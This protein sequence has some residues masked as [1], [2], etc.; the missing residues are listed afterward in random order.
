MRLRLRFLIYFLLAAF[1]PFTALGFVVQNTLIRQLEED[2]RRQLETRVASAE[3]RTDEMLAAD[4]RAVEALCAH[5]LVV[6]R[7]LLDL[8]TDRFGPQQEASMV[9]LL[10]PMMRG[11]RFDVL[12]LLDARSGERRGRILGAGHYAERVGG[13]EPALVDAIA[14]AGD[15]P[16]VTQVRVREGTESASDVDVLVSGC[17][18]ARDGA[19]VAVLAGRTL[20]DRFSAGIL[21]DV[22]PVHFAL[23][24]PGAEVELPGS[25]EP[26]VVH[27]FRD[28][29]GS[30]VLQLVARIDD[31]PLRAD[32]E[33]LKLRGIYIA[34][35]ALGI[36]LLL[37]LLLTLT[38]RRGLSQLEEAARRVASGDLES[39]MRVRGRDEVGSAMTAFN[40][41]TRELAATRRKLLRAER[42]AAWREVARRIAHEIKNPLQPIQMEVETLRKLHA[43]KHPK[44]DEE[45]DGSTQVILDEVKRMNEM[46]TEFSRFAR[47]PRPKATRFDLR[48]IAEHVAG[49]HGSSGQLEV[50]VPET[51]LEIRGDRDQLT[52]VLVNLVQNGADAAQA[53]HGDAGRVW[54]RIRETE[55]GAEVRVE[56]D[57][58]GIAAEDR[59]RVFE[60]YYTTKS[61]GTGLGLAI[62][63]R[64]VGDHDGNVDVEEGPEGGAAFVI[65]LP[66]TG[67]PAEIAASTVGEISL[68]R[69]AD[70]EATVR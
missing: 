2:H 67:P 58:P 65:Q 5:D 14:R 21:G 13:S 23:A 45:F 32:V 47:L 11:R 51:P 22:S 40:E 3:R 10:P 62:V 61:K 18:K 6:D 44:F 17:T 69:P 4:R 27:A 70:P 7:L 9:T 19:A 46:V 26:S 20:G 12:F 64:I 16:F 66:R 29:R 49:L 30:E 33:A 34:V 41:M 25:A 42:I 50:E 8:A 15:E 39:Q 52:Q 48:D 54:L 68:G 63:H 57:G 38:L 53:R 55:E 28:P 60:P 31:A 36:A 56:D 35:A 37:A 24:S 1:V 43:R 59:M